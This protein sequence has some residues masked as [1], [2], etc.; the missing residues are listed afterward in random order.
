MKLSCRKLIYSSILSVGSILCAVGVTA[1]VIPDNTTNTTVEVNGNDFSINQGD[2]AGDNLFHSFS[3]F[4]VPTDGSAFFNNASDIVNIFSRVTGGNISNIDG[5]IGANGTANLFLL[6]PAGII[7]GA[8]ARLNIGGSFYGST[9]DSIV[10]EDGEFS[11]TDVNNPPLLTI[12]APIGLNFRDNPT[13][14]RV[15]DSRLSVSPGKSLV[16]VGGEVNLDNASLVASG[17]NDTIFGAEGN[18]MLQGGGG[19]D[20]VEGGPDRDTLI[21]TRRDIIDGG[22]G[23]DVLVSDGAG[24]ILTGGLGLDVFG[25]N[26]T[27]KT[28][29]IPDQ[30]TDYQPGE[31]IVIRGTTPTGDI[32]YN[33]TTGILS[34][35]GEEI[36]QLSPGSEL[37]LGDVEYL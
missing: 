21:G 11:A 4:S 24:N 26:L 28:G 10:F 16:L 6:N 29:D 37:D 32:D 30:I 31:T 36:V 15:N 2:R 9:A 8:G 12:N 22:A 34:V 14:I 13:P 27:R 3:D 25:I 7:F 1:Q 17:G 33:P 19:N 23:R 18:D 35:N 5:F 20:S